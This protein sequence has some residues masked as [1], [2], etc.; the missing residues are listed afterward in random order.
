MRFLHFV[1]SALSVFGGDPCAQCRVDPRRTVLCSAHLE[2][3]LATLREERSIMARSKDTTERV[4]ALQRVANLTSAH[5]NAPSPNVARF[6]ADG[7]YDDALP[8]RK[9]ALQLLIDGQHRDETIKGV[10]D[11][12][13]AALRAW[14]DVEGRIATL[15]GDV[16][17]SGSIMSRQELE[18]WPAYVEALIAALGDVRDERAYRELLNVLKWPFDRTPGRFYLCAARTALT[19][20]SRKGVE[21]VLD[22]ALALEAELSAGRVPP[23][24][25][26]SSGL[27]GAMMKPLDNANSH[28]VEEMLEA[29]VEFAKRKKIAATPE[30]KLGLGAAWRSWF[31]SAK[32]QFTERMTLLE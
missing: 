25:G 14:R 22:C 30:P 4:A 9:R 28:D 12:W 7:L 3:E 16:Q 19:V 29:L 27:L 10:I 8:V 2:E 11:G 18:D 6:L 23:R 21:A 26:P 13:K 20:E 1:V 31:K 32:D 5:T 15:T 17:K 24:F